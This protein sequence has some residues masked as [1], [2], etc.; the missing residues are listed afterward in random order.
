[1]T[2]VGFVLLTTMD[3]LTASVSTISIQWDNT[4]RKQGPE[5]MEHSHPS[6]NPKVAFEIDIYEKADRE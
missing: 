4:C 5:K 2:L 6:K 1:M 3:T